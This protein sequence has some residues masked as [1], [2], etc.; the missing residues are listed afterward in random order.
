M[1][2]RGW[3]AESV[4]RWRP[5]AR[6]EFLQFTVG[7][8]PRQNALLEGIA[9][10]MEQI[11]CT[12]GTHPCHNTIKQRGMPTNCRNGPETNQERAKEQAMQINSHQQ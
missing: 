12:V 8:Y 10:T 6:G 5:E 2:C 7:S 3:L 9:P 11:C 1:G 4:G